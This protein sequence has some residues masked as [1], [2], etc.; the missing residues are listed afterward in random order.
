MKSKIVKRNIS[1]R[2]Y[3]FFIYIFKRREKIIDGAFIG[4][5][6]IKKENYI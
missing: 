2:D 5:L 6:Y 3:D 4:W 1:K